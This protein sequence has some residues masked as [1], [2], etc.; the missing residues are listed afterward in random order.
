MKSS[1]RAQFRWARVLRPSRRGGPAGPEEQAGPRGTRT[2]THWTLTLPTT[3]YSKKRG[4]K[5]RPHGYTHAFVCMYVLRYL[6]HVVGHTNV[7]SI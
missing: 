4:I 1:W 7:C 3:T 6:G 2:R 5:K